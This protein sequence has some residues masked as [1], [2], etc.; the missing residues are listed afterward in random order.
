MPEYQLTIDRPDTWMRLD[1][2]TRGY[3]TAA[4]WTL[5]DEDGNSCDDL[6]FADI[7]DETIAAAVGDCEAFQA[8]NRADLDEASEEQGRDDESHGHDFWLTRNHHGAGFW[9]RGYSPELSKRLTDAAHVWGG[10]D[11]YLGD[12]G[13]VYQA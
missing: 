11:W 7:A 6:T 9:D 3:I 13:R 5:T 1:S 12:D 4:M 8:D 10:C 2:F